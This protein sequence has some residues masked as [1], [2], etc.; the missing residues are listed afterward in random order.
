MREKLTD[1]YNATVSGY[2]PAAAGWYLREQN[3]AGKNVYHPVMAWRECSG[4]GPLKDGVLIPVLPV[5]MTGKAANEI[6]GDV[7]YVLDAYLT[8]NGDGSFSDRGL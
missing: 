1:K 7:I 8:P 6:S 5:G 3:N 4:V 2:V